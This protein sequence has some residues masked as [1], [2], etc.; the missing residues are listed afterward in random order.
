MAKQKSKSSTGV[1]GINAKTSS[2]R[3]SVKKPNLVFGN[4]LS[5]ILK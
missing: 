3:K 1:Y 5:K 2:I 4:D